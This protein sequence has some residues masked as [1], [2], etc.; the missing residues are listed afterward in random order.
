M[1]LLRRRE[2]G[3]VTLVDATAR[4]NTRPAIPGRHQY[5]EAELADRLAGI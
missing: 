4:G 2:A 3:E 1:R 5:P